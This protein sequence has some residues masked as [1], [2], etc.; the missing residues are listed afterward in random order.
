MKIE[1]EISQEKIRNLIITALEGGSNYWYFLGDDAVALIKEKS[2][3]GLI[4]A[5]SERM[6]M[7]IENGAEIPITDLEDEMEVLGNISM[8]S[9]KKGLSLMAS[10]QPEQFGN[11]QSENNWDAET[12]DV[13]F[14]Y[15]VM[16]ELV[17]G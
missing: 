15:A 10:Q 1:I 2:P 3:N 9:I 12:A 11:L 4:I 6:G 17:F 16:G 5:L 14:Q 7:A 13:F 8:E